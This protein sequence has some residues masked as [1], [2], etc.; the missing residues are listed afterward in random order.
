MKTKFL[1]QLFLLAFVSFSLCSC[2]DDSLT[3]TKSQSTEVATIKPI[4][5]INKTAEDIIYKP[6]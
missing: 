1:T 5:P 4:I 3:D 6:K 2:T